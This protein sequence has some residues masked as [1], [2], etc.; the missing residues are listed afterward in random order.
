MNEI[1]NHIDW[2]PILTAFIALLLTVVSRLVIK[3]AVPWLK[4]HNLTDAADVAVR[5]AE[6][7]YGRYHG[8]EKL[9]AAIEMLKAQGF[10][11]TNEDVIKAIKAAWQDLNLQMINAGIKSNE[12]DSDSE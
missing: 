1:L 8:E 3:Y 6:A 9:N 12:A 5:A 4:R 10:V 7:I 11:V 2:T